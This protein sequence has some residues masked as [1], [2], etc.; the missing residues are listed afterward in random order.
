[1]SLQGPEYPF[2]N[3]ITLE[4]D[5]YA[6]PYYTSIEASHQA[7][8]ARQTS[9]REFTMTNLKKRKLVMKVYAARESALKKIII[10]KIVLIHYFKDAHDEASNT[11]F[12]DNNGDEYVAT[13][14]KNFIFPI[15]ESNFE[16]MVPLKPVVKKCYCN[17]DLKLSSIKLQLTFERIDIPEGSI[18]IESYKIL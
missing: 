5:C 15:T 17:K 10:S 13:L 3:T 18:S 14:I 2:A 1:M 9:S 12:C 16:I 4:Y 8:Q 11:C 6:C 7:Q